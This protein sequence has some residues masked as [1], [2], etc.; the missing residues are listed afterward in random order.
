MTELQ[1]YAQEES[2]IRA[3]TFEVIAKNPAFNTQYRNDEIFE[4]LGDF[5]SSKLIDISV[6]NCGNDIIE[7]RSQKDWNS[8][9]KA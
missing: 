7:K 5:H 3:K 8:D 2:T 1:K 9:D 4:N 6:K